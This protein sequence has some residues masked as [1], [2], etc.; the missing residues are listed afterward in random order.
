MNSGYRSKSKD[1]RNIVGM[2]LS[3]DKRFKRVRRG[4]YTLKG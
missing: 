2:A 3:Q 4:A 1:F